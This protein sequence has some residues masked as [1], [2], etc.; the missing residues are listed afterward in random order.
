MTSSGPASDTVFRS[1]IRGWLVVAS[2]L[3]LWTTAAVAGQS[4]TSF[5]GTEPPSALTYDQP[6]SWFLQADPSFN[7][8][9]SR[10][11][12]FFVHPTTDKSMTRWNQDPDDK[13]TN[14]W[15]QASVINRQAV[16]FTDCC[17]VF[18]PR[19]RQASRLALFNMDGDGAK[20][21]DLAYGD[22]DRAF[23]AFVDRIGD[24]PFILAGHS[25]GAF[26]LARL[27]ERRIDNTSLAS[28][29]IVAYVVGLNLSEGE[30]GRTYHSVSI[31]DRP[32]Q[33][34]CVVG[35]NAVLPEANIGEI[36]KSSVKRF[37]DRYGDV[38]GKKILCINPLTFDRDRTAASKLASQGSAP[39]EPGEGSLPD[40]IAGEVSAKCDQGSLVVE[41]SSELHLKP[42]PNGSMHYHDLGLFFTDIQRNVEY[43][44]SAYRSSNTH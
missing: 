41:P 15:T 20:A 37:T 29:M 32:D 13:V 40:R 25:Q 22:V 6:G 14:A 24:R 39:G 10:V 33:T 3:T 44:I 36:A 7:S 1:V 2:A 19:Y 43:R 35:W 16:I 17:D 27:I 31:C 9:I 18:A 28:K 42:L 38:S 4:V 5:D 30:F 23:L 11:P 34:Q 26:H 21:F 12:V 8:D